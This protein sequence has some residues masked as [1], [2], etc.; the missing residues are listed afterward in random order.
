MCCT[1]GEQGAKA[2][3]ISDTIE[4][5][6]CADAMPYENCVALFVDNT[7]TMVGVKNSVTSRSKN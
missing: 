6:C 3:A 4:E 2:K 7:S 5:K 1:E